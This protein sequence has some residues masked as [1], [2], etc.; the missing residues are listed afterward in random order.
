MNPDGDR[1]RAPVAHT[2]GDSQQLDLIAEL[3]RKGYVGGTDAGDPFGVDVTGD[4][5]GVEGDAGQ[6]GGLGPGVETLDVSCRV[7]L[8]IAERLSLRK[9]HRVVTSLLAHRGEHVVRRPV[10]DPHHADDPL[11]CERVVEKPDKGYSA[12]DRGLVEQV[13][14]ALLGRREQLGPES[15]EELLVGGDDG[16]AGRES[17]E[18]QAAA[19]A[20]CRR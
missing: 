18:H 17:R 1:R 3:V 14:S 9:G 2:L 20:R 4:D 16:L 15:G 11:A 5:V 6:D 13:D 8:G 10:H 7:G 12:G 19:P